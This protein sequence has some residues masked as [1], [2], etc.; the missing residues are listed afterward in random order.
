MAMNR[1]LP[2]DQSAG[3]PSSPGPQGENAAGASD[4]A[5]GEAG[6]AASSRSGMGSLGNDPASF[7]LGEVNPR[8]AGD[9]GRL[10]QLESEDT[11]V[12]RRIEVSPEYRRQIEAYF[13]AIAEQGRQP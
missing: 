9:W 6:N 11:S 4:S 5:A 12:Q 2:G 3:D 13:R 8:G 7:R 10:R 1:T